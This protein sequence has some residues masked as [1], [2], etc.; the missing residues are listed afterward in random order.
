MNDNWEDKIY[1]DLD[2]QTD[3]KNSFYFHINK[4]IKD[5]KDHLNKLITDYNKQ[6]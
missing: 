2:G 6:V 1:K 5:I 3:E 4:E